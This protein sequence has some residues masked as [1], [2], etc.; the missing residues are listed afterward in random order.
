MRDIKLY[1]MLREKLLGEEINGITVSD[2]IEVIGNGFEFNQNIV[3]G[4]DSRLIVTVFADTVRSD[5][6]LG[7][8][9]EEKDVMP[10]ALDFD[11][12]FVAAVLVGQF[13]GKMVN[14]RLNTGRNSVAVV[15]DSLMGNLHAMHIE[16]ES[17]SFSQ[18]YSVVDMVGQNQSENVR[19]SRN[20]GQIHDWDILVLFR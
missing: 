10:N 17:G 7:D 12:G 3:N 2:E 15:G 11:I 8:V 20:I 19:R 6:F 9:E 16:H 1:A 14:K 18:R 13:V 4:E 5:D